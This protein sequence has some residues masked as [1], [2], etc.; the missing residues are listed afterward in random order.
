MMTRENYRSCMYL[1]KGHPIHSTYCTHPERDAWSDMCGCNGC[2][3]CPLHCRQATST[4]QP[5]K[6]PH[7]RP[8]GVNGLGGAE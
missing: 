2:T 4:D 6:C 7:G 5:D 1:K 8:R 3:G